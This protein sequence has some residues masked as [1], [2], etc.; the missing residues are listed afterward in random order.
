MDS[1]PIREGECSDS[2]R[3]SPATF[4]KYWL[5]LGGELQYYECVAD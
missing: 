5:A 3:C 1:L 2:L 4:D